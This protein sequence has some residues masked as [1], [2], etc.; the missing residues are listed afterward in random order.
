MGNGLNE[1][2]CEQ[3]NIMA[4]G[5]YDCLPVTGLGLEPAFWIALTVILLGVLFYAVTD[6]FDNKG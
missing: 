1:V 2:L 6:L 5:E 4:S 3:Y